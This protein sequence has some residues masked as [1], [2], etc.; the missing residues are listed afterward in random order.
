MNLKLDN[1][2]QVSNIILA[3]E[4]R[5]KFER[6]IL[7]DEISEK[8]TMEIYNQFKKIYIVCN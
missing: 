5:L 8:A 4:E 1:M 7:G 2:L 6:E 3:L